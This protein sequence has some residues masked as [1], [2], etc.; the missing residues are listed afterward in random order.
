M[1]SRRHAG[2]VT[3]DGGAEVRSRWATLFPALLLA[4]PQACVADG[5]QPVSTYPRRPTTPGAPR[6]SRSS[7]GNRASRRPSTG[8]RRRR[9]NQSG[10]PAGEAARSVLSRRREGRR[11]LNG[12]G[13][14]RRTAETAE[15]RL[16]LPYL[17]WGP[18]GSTTLP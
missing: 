10:P 8:E 12:G 6:S 2:V 13:A 17:A 14:P 3:A 15:R 18:M 11:H 4:Q 5:A 9:G 1:A 7:V 16:N